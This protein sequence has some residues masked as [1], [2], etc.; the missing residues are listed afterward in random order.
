[1]QEKS[2]LEK[3]EVESTDMLS[4]KRTKVRHSS[5]VKRKVALSRIKRRLLKHVW[6]VR[7]GI[8]A[9]FLLGIFLVFFAMF[10]FLR[11]TS[12]GFYLDLASDFVFTPQE[13]IKSIEGRTNLLILGKGGQNHEAPDLTDTIIF[14]S[15]YHPAPSR[16]QGVSKKPS[17][18]LISLPRDIWIPELRAKLNSTYYWGN[19]KEEG[20]GL[21]L[22]KS[23]VEEI[24]GQPVHYGLVVDFEGFKETIDVVGGVMVDVENSF[25]D[26]W[27]PIPGREDDEC[28]GDLEYKCR[29][30]TIRFEKGR[31]MMNGETALKFVRSRNAEGDEGTDIARASRQQRLIAAIKEKA[32]SREIIF[33]PKKLLEI[34]DVLAKY[35]ETDIDANAAAILA[36]RIYEAK[37]NINYH[38]LS[39][40]FLINP[41]K[42]YRYDRLYVFIPKAESWNDVH[43]WV[44]CTLGISACTH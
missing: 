8:I 26:E 41:P 32:L 2:V 3:K 37:D 30:E 18:S 10:S 20:G 17:V 33:S 14:A 19:Q 28:D 27:F 44:K 34:K 35:I 15:I 1:M 36:R 4:E 43:E 40:D 13:K 29:Y 42:S 31:Q 11:K 7:F 25:T 12:L 23:S 9:G 38:V 21:K 16:L 24:I 22:T 39:E 6:L 5:L